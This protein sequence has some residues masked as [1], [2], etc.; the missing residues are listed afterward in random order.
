MSPDDNQF[1]EIYRSLAPGLVIAACSPKSMITLR[2]FCFSLKGAA[3]R[4]GSDVMLYTGGAA[5]IDWEAVG[6]QIQEHGNRGVRVFVINRFEDPSPASV[7]T[8]MKAGHGFDRLDGS[9]EHNL[10]GILHQ[11]ALGSKITLLVTTVAEKESQ[12]VKRR[13]AR[14]LGQEQ[15][16]FI[17]LER[18][19][20]S[21]HWYSATVTT[22]ATE[23]SYGPLDFVAEC[24]QPLKAQ[25]QPAA[26]SVADPDKRAEA[27]AEPRPSWLRRLFG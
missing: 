10:A 13:A 1:E 20:L 2:S 15:G 12:I 17:A 9:I 6:A 19:R 8:R 7:I 4:C 23:R 18:P 27:L 25:P 5:P 3:I 21:D 14:I 24:P 26:E 11:A 16:V 22:G